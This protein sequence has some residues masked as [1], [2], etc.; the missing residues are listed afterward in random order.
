MAGTSHRRA[1]RAARR[2]DAEV[3]AIL[4]AK[5]QDAH[6]QR[7]A[8]GQ[9]VGRLAA[10]LW[11][12]RG[13]A[14]IADESDSSARRRVQR[15]VAAGVLERLPGHPVMFRLARTPTG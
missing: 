13:L 15:M 10:L 1:T 6:A 3:L 11:G 14:A 9:H 4:A 2:T 8:V 12:Y 7:A 5:Q